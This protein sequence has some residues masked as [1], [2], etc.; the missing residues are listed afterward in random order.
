MPYVFFFRGVIVIFESHARLR[1]TNYAGSFSVYRLLLFQLQLVRVRSFAFVVGSAV[2]IVATWKR[3]RAVM[4]HSLKG[5]RL[6]FALLGFEI[7]TML[8]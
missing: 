1:P 2:P 7:S 3:V 6:L 4:G 5:G 8:L